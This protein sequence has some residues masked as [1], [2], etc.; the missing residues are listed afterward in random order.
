MKKII[1]IILT[2][3]LIPFFILTIKDIY[4][5]E[6]NPTLT[7]NLTTTDSTYTDLNNHTLQE[8]FEDI[9]TDWNRQLPNGVFTYQQRL[10]NGVYVLDRYVQQSIFNGSVS[11]SWFLN[12]TYTDTLRFKISVNNGSLS[13]TAANNRGYSVFAPLVNSTSDLETEGW[14]INSNVLYIVINKSRLATNDVAGLRTYLASNNLTFFYQLASPILNVWSSALT[15]EEMDAWY[16]I[17]QTYHTSYTTLTLGTAT[18]TTYTS[19]QQLILDNEDKDFKLYRDDVVDEDHYRLTQESGY[20]SITNDDNLEIMRIN[21][22]DT[23][24]SSL[25]VDD[26]IDYKLVGYNVTSYID[27]S[28]DNTILAF[29]WIIPILLIGG[30]FFVIFSHR[31]ED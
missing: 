11:E 15:V 21:D 26:I 19:L 24:E 17:Y 25:Q 14:L 12:D 3:L 10:D 2:L 1:L 6:V 18:P 13:V 20:I 5:E 22:D 28:F 30:F 29:V 27:G 4:R 16:T 8:V 23:F 7:Y 31:K 9:L